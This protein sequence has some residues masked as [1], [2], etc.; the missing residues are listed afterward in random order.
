MRSSAAERPARRAARFAFSDPMAADPNS[1]RL[2]THTE[3]SLFVE[4]IVVATVAIALALALARLGP[5]V[6]RG[7]AQQ[8][9]NLYRSNP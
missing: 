7:Y 2:L 5:S 6:V 3:G 8:Q 1:K 9:Q 4:Y